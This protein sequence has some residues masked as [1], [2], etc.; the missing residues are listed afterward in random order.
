MKKNIIVESY[1]S[2]HDTNSDLG[3]GRTTSRFHKSRSMGSEYPYIEEDDIEDY[4]DDETSHSIFKKSL[5]PV[6]T[7]PFSKIGTNSFYFVAG[8]TKLSDCFS[9][10]DKVLLEV[11]ALGDSMSTIPMKKKKASSGR[12]GGASFPSGVGSFKRTGTKRGYFSAPPKLKYQQKEKVI[13]DEEDVPIENLR[14]LSD[15]QD[16]RNGTFS[17]R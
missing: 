13:T 1:G 12:S 15:K 14:D 4:E 9:R 5:Y 11:H 17:P 8:N 16:R 2:P 10:P 6:K 7:D 3:Y